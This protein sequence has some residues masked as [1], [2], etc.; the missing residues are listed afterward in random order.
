[1]KK[2][3]ILSIIVAVLIAG[4]NDTKSK[5]DKKV[6]KQEST[7]VVKQEVKKVEPVAKTVIK[8]EKQKV[9]KPQQKELRRANPAK[10]Q[11][12]FARKL[13]EACGINGGQVAKKHTQDEWS[14]IEKSG[15]IKEEIKKICPKASD[16]ELKDKY[17]ENYFDF[18]YNFA[19]DSGNIPSC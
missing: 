13:K 5:S 12:L 8:E 1:M 9:E 3:I 17:L 4:C 7:P 18:F 2:N 19:S 6:S 15:K 11:K 16:D 14:A 10:G